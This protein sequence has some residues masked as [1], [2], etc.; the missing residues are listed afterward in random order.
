MDIFLP[1]WVFLEVEKPL[2]FKEM[3]VNR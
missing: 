1:M 2:S 3:S